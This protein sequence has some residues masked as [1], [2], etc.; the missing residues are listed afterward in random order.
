MPYNF[1]ED[2]KSL[3]LMV[4]EVNSSTIFLPSNVAD[5]EK[6]EYLKQELQFSNPTSLLRAA[7]SQLLPFRDF[8]TTEG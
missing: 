3:S 1:V 8:S 2:R 4:L 6:N 5:F 7:T